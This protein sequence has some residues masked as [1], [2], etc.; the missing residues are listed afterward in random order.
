MKK[1][2]L[3]KPTEAELSVGHAHERFDDEGNLV[4]EDI[5]QGLRDA[6]ETLVAEIPSDALAAA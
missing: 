1:S 5:R 6:L 2:K 3:S 4:D